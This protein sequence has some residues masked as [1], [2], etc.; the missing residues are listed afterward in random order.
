MA[1]MFIQKVLRLSF[2]SNFLD[3]TFIPFPMFI[4]DTRVK[5]NPLKPT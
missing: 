4:P 1:Y 5:K 3:P 2:L